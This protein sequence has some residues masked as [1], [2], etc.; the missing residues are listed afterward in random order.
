VTRYR[1]TRA[2]A[3]STEELVEA[4]GYGYAHSCVTSENFPAR[5]RAAGPAEIVLLRFEGAVTAAEVLAEASRRGLGR[6][7]YEDALHFGAEHPEAQREH[8]IVFLHEPWVG[9]FGRRDVLSLWTNAG[10]RELGL[11]GF[12]D[13]FGPEHR[14]AFVEPAPGEAAPRP[15]YGEFAWAYDYLIDRPVPAECAGMAAALAR[16]GIGPGA[17]LLDAG[18]GTGRYAVELARRG[19]VVTGIERSPALLAQALRRP[20]DAAV[21]VRFEAGD[22]L[23]LPAGAGFDAIVCRGVLNDLVETAERAAVFPAFARALRPGGALLF[24]VRDWEASAARKTEQPVFERRATTPRGRL[25]FR[26]VTRLDLATR[27]LLVAE[28]HTLTTEAGEITARHDFVMRCW[29]RDELDGALRAAGFAAMEYAGTYEGA[30][31]G[32]GDRIVIAASR[33]TR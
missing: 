7:S 30:P 14:F 26:S 29:S 20:V 9:Y 25:V 27:R 24:D 32:V 19:F 33:D 17:T 23:A 4:G 28:R 31:L 2:G 3:R 13:R 15:F 1:I 18:C 5:A 16:R 6:P 10:R 8:P 22:L 11:E 21:R 12:D